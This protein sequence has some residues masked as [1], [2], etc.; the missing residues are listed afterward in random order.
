MAEESFPFQELAEGDRTVSAAMFAKHL[1]YVRTRGV[2]QGVDNTLAAGPSNPAALSVDLDTGGAFVGLTEL[3]AYRNT[4]PRTLALAAADLTHPRHDLLVLDMD[5]DAGPPD[6]RRVTAQIL[7]GAPAATPLDP[8]LT[9]TENH[10]QLPL[11]RILVPALA[12]SISAGDITDLRTYSSP[13]NTPGASVP[14][15]EAFALAP[16]TGTHTLCFDDDGLQQNASKCWAIRGNGAGT[17]E[18]TRYKRAGTHVWYWDEGDATDAGQ[19]TGIA[20]TGITVG[21][22]PGGVFV[23]DGPNNYVYMFYENAGALACMRF[24]G[25]DL[26]TTP[27]AVTLTG[28]DGGTYVASNAAVIAYDGSEGDFYLAHFST[29]D[30]TVQRFTRTSATEFTQQASFGLGANAFIY[31]LGVSTTPEQPI[32]AENTN[33][34]DAVDR[35]NMSGVSQASSGRP[36]GNGTLAMIDSINALAGAGL[37]RIAGKTCFFNGS[38]TTDGVVEITEAVNYG[39]INFKGTA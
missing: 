27:T 1:G 7:T 28:F 9:Q 22:R 36:L 10:Y 15:N 17:V 18:I 14:V 11:A 8:A 38:S 35:L 19:Q 3:R 4:L 33:N 6:T 39:S 37:T 26:T 32:V 12:T 20:V 24:D 21:D 34:I 13:A 23:K 2:I 25:D 29:T 31:F 16:T 30:T 5:T